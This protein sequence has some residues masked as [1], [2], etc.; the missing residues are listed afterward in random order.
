MNSAG[1]F[2]AASALAGVLALGGVS[3]LQAADAAIDVMTIKP[4]SGPGAERQGLKFLLNLEFGRKQAVTYYLNEK[5]VCKLTL[6]VAD[7][8]NGVDVPNLSTVRFEAPIEAAKSARF[9][10]AEGKALEFTCHVGAEQMS[11]RT[12]NQVAGR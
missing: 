4:L 12:I 5:G 11:V 3:T 2:V 8:F 6:M 7:A 10:T 9:D 1:N